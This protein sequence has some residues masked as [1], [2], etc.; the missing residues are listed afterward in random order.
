MLC[1]LQREVLDKGHR[2]RTVSLGYEGMMKFCHVVLVMSLGMTA[3]LVVGAQTPSAGPVLVASEA[4]PEGML[5]DLLAGSGHDSLLQGLAMTPEIS[6][7]IPKPPEAPVPVH[8]LTKMDRLTLFWN[9]TY[10]SPGA[11]VGLSAGAFVDQVRHTPA[12]W[13]GDGS[14]YTR[15]FASEYGQLAARNVIHEGLAGI[16]GLDPRYSICNCDGKLHRGAHALKMTF[17]TYRQDGRLVLDMPQ[18]AGAYGSG[19]VSTYWYPHHLYSPLVQGV[20]FGHE[21]MGEV[22]VGNLIQEFGPDIKRSL[23]LHS[24]STLTHPRPFDDD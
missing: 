11:F 5:P 9:D 7:A 10:A 22:L 20:Q 14:S 18:I 17:T 21:Q 24:L 23:H 12:K 8:K 13:D 19:I 2:Q 1:V 15:R 6:Q 16:A 3:D 4:M